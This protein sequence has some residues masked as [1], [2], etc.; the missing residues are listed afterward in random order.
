MGHNNGRDIYDPLYR[1]RNY[2]RNIG[3]YLIGLMIVFSA[4][5]L[6]AYTQKE[7]IDCHKMGSKKSCRQID[8]E[9]F[10]A[11]VHG[12]EASCRDCHSEVK[13]ESHKTIRGSGEVDCRNCHNQDN[14][15]G[16]QSQ[17]RRPRCQSCHTRHNI[18]RKDNKKSS[19]HPDQ[20]RQTCGS[21][22]ARQ[23]GETNYLSWLPSLQ[24]KSH[25]KQ[26][27]SRDYS[28]NNCIGCHQG[29]AAHGEIHPIVDQDCYQCH[30]TLEGNSLL[31]GYIHPQAD[32]KR[33]PAIYASAMIYQ[34]CLVFLVWSGF[35][36]FI[37]KFSAKKK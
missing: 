11:S 22:H 32:V 14:R 23:S 5:E 36:F 10:A 12:D 7:C 15:H 8:I 18:L 19:L 30:I 17:I 3:F 20:L 25:G 33:Q 24:I 1:T 27:F 6:W 9:M 35:R 2:K 28:D 26:D 4:N 31:Y 37:R 34:F 29:K 13:G 21:C 16:L